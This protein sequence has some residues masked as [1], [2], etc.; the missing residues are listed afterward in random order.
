MLR[1]KKA[2]EADGPIL[3]T[4]H[5]GITDLVVP[6]KVGNE[7]FGALYLG[8]CFTTNP[9]TSKNNCARI[10]TKYG[11]DLDELQQKASYIPRLKR[12]ELRRWI[13]LLLCVKDY[14]E[15]AEE[16]LEVR[17]ERLAAL[18]VGG[19]A[20]VG[21]MKKQSIETVPNYFLEKIRPHSVPIR[22]AVDILRNNYWRQVGQAEVARRS[23]LSPSQFSRRFK[24]ETGYTF[25]QCLSMARIS[26]AAFL[27]K[28][29][30]LGFAEISDML[31]Y[32]SSSSLQRAFKR[33]M[34]QT[35]R[36]FL[37]QLPPQWT[38]YY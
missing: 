29:T 17:K 15:Q 2:A 34:N 9:N 6:L 14:I 25:R 18:P 5:A 7:N 11:H 19:D 8:Q 32:E 12:S 26:A 1:A 35:P 16:L 28:R 23:G 30:S 3:H 13:T 31:G 37:R 20:M 10:A 36:T 22:K 38:S 27:L 4:C 33:Q 21:S 24:I